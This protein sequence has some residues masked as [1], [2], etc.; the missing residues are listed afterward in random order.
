MVVTTSNDETAELV[1]RAQKLARSL[2]TQFFKREKRTLKALLQLSPEVFVVNSHRGLSYYKESPEEVFFHPNMAFLRIKQLRDGQQDTLVSVCG[3]EPGMSFFDG[4]VGLASDALV[5]AYAVGEAGFVVGT[6]LSRPLYTLTT[7]G[8]D[9]YQERHPEWKPLIE[10]LT[11]HNK[12]NFHY[13]SGLAANSIDVV[14]FDFMFEKT[15][16][17]STGIQVIKAITAADI[18]TPERVAEA[19]RVA[20]RRV[21]AKSGYSGTPLTDLGFEVRKEYRRK[22]FYF[23]VLEVK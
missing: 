3:L 5:A 10:R 19:L 16:A 14:Y 2:E 9:F 7:Y 8:L 1:E 11:I 12:D 22:N 18:L 20:K 21:V 4:T 13:L 15:V 6:E 17:T 23:G